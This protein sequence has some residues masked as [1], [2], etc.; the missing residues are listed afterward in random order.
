MRLKFF[1]LVGSLAL[2]LQVN[3]QQNV[4]AILMTINGKPITKAEFEYSYHKNGSVEGAVE[5][6]T[7]AEYVP[8]FVDYKLKVAAAEAAHLDTLSSFKQEFRTYRDMQLTP[9]LVDTA[10]IDSV[11]QVV[12]RNTERQLKGADLIRT[13]HIL[14]RIPQKAS[15]D[16]KKVAEAKADSIYKLL[17]GGAD[18][19]ELATRFSEDPGSA[20][21]GGGL[22]L[23]GPG[24]FVKEYENAAYKLKVGEIS[25]PV[26][27]PFGYHIIKML[28]RKPLDPYGKVKP[29][30]IEL[31][32]KQNIEEASSVHRINQLVR[33]SGGRLTRE[34][35]LDSVLTAHIDEN[36]DLKFLI[37]EYHD[38][39]LL[40]EISKREVW[41][42]AASDTLN[43][44]K[45]YK[46]HKPDYRWDSPRFKGF[47]F[48]SKNPKLAKKVRKLLKKNA[49]GNWKALLKDSF[50]K[51]SV[52]VAVSGPYLCKEGENGYVDTYAFG[53]KTEHPSQ[54]GYAVSGVSGKVLKQ[55]K[56]W[57]DVRSQVIS[58]YQADRE[59][60]WVESLR[61]RFSCKIYEDVLR[62]LQ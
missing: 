19:A 11:A 60:A 61:K 33:A 39:L 34:S 53:R 42:K 12:Y 1:L 27:S 31:L 49:E 18:F 15:P 14:I 21:K 20:S 7:V 10:F 37:Q 45:W 46:A 25:A 56:S 57:L 35:V 4:D 30:I 32:K 29:E 9:Y 44:E 13:A 50:N 47:V 51:D 59:K 58:D 24:S 8:M 6:K 55:P 2:C 3:A 23:V 22:P 48:H 36:P 52:V 17:L 28:E 38:G 40:Y 41:D 16:A 54:K 43:L 62:T 5:K 26:L